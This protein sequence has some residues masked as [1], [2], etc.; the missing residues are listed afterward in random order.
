M[1]PFLDFKQLNAELRDELIAA[2][3]RV[4]DS[5]WYING[6][7]VE[8]FEAEFARYCGVAHCIGV[9]NGLDALVLV[10]R[11][12]LQM[13]RLREGDEVIVPSNTFVASVLAVSQNRL[14]PVLVEPDPRSFNLCP[15]RL[16]QAL[17]DRTRVVLPVHLYGQLAD[18]PRI[19]DWARRHGLLVLED[20]AQAHGARLGGRS[21]GAWGDAAGFSFY[22]GKNLGAIGDAGAVV[23]D[24]QDLADVLAALRNYGSREKYHNERLGVNSRLDEIQAA[25]LRVKLRALDR[26]IEQRRAIAQVYGSRIRNPL[27]ELP[28]LAMDGPESHVWHLYVVRTADRDGLQRHLAQAGVGSLVHYPVPPHRQQAYAGAFRDRYPLSEHLHDTVLSLPL[29]PYLSLAQIDAVVDACNSYR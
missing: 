18:M 29:G 5:G 11:A 26:S 25:M 17:S 28:V 6:P 21:A 4:I 15:H 8:A 20:A 2:C 16:E 3:A 12:W 7:E 13:G 22:P 19:A 24:D 9:A 23:T 10:L 27:I 14:T 1:I